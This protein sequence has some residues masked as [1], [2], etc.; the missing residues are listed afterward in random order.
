MDK[1]IASIP[2]LDELEEIIKD[3]E[4]RVVNVGGR[5]I[6]SHNFKHSPYINYKYKSLIFPRQLTCRARKV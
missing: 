6:F 2:T 3:I 4:A 1:E 5:E